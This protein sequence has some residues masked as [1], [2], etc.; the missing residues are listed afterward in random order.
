MFFFLSDVMSVSERETCYSQQTTCSNWS[1]DVKTSKD[2][3][4]EVMSTLSNGAYEPLRSQP[5]Q[6][7]ADLKAVS[8]KY[9]IRRALS[10]FKYVCDFIAPKQGPTLLQYVIDQEC[11]NDKAKNTDND[12]LTETVI[13]A[14]KTA[15][16][17]Q[18]RTQIL[19]LIATKFS[20]SKLLSLIDD[21][22]IHR[23]DKARKHAST[24]GPGQYIAPAKITRV[25][26]SKCQIQ[27][28][29][30][31]IS[32]P[33]Y[34]QT[35][36]FGSK[37]LKLSSGVHVKIPKVI[38]TMIGSRLISLYNS[39]CQE[40]DVQCPSRATLFRI[41]KGCAASQ[42]KSL[43]GLDNHA[44]EGIASID[45]LLRIADKLG[46][47]GLEQE[48]VNELKSKLSSI[49]TFYKHEFM[50]H[51]TTTSTCF[52]H[53]IQYALSDKLCN[54]EHSETCLSCE[55]LNNT[56]EALGDM[57]ET[58]A[59]SNEQTKEEVEYD[60]KQSN[61]KLINWRNHIVRSVNQDKCKTDILK[62]LKEHQV[63]LVADWA[64]K[65]LPQNFRETQ[66][67]WFG[68]Q[69]ISW[70]ICCALY[71]SDQQDSEDNS[72]DNVNLEIKSFVHLLSN[73]TQ[74]WFSVSQI[75]M[76]TFDLLKEQ[77]PRLTEVYLKSD[78]AG[79]YH[80][81]PLM[82]FLWTNRSLNGLTVKE[83]NFSEV[84]SGKDICDA[85]TGNCRL[86]I[87]NYINEGNNVT[88]V[89]EMKNALESH[90]G[91]V[92]TYV[93]VIDIN[94]E[95]QPTLSGQLK[96]CNISSLNNFIFEDEGLR[97][98]KAYKVGDPDLINSSSIQS[99]SRNMTNECDYKVRQV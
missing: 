9:Y 3:F 98:Y 77:N 18:T 27:H 81:L 40:N 86:H 1:Q 46:E 54:H 44:S 24:H 6:P 67:D 35:V 82:A 49:K 4:N 59:F 15:E 25:R 5:S 99:I 51:L 8:K 55:D 96:S 41:I 61:E 36:G 16:D 22:S 88:E 94:M 38:R 60:I 10:A 28:F 45:I 90:G 32:S 31:F 30:E 74:G 48:K 69:G 11:D 12:A 53:C 43:H 91:V 56:M 26:L 57:C 33:A 66:S 42:L 73:G 92:N 37:T 89:F 75:F 39:Y 13:E 71:L 65:F 7:L 50:N 14:Y 52:N 72:N 19:S 29:I 17:H 62:N 87:L 76:H 47:N 93:S 79:C 85:R 34:L 95:R 80:S 23:I 70:H 97:V 21:L 83:Y 78:N 63:L 20:K 84:Q 68:K 2:I 64:M 58:L